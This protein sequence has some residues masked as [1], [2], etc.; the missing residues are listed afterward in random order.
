MTL[1]APLEGQ[2]HLMEEVKSTPKLRKGPEVRTGGPTKIH[3]QESQS[4]SPR[5]EDDAI[6]N[7]VL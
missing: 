5:P 7:L 4:P 6:S 1:S 2:G 3:T